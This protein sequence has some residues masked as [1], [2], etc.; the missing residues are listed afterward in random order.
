MSNVILRARKRREQV[1]HLA[2]AID[3]E[4]LF[5]KREIERKI[6]DVEKR[7]KYLDAIVEE[8]GK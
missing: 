8:L 6:P 1:Q 4:Y 2:I 5:L 7:I 3:P